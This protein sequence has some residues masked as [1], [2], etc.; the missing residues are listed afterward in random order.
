MASRI[1]TLVS[2]TLYIFLLVTFTIIGVA[3]LIVGVVGV[4]RYIPT[5]AAHRTHKN[6]TCLIVDVDYDS[7]QHSCYYVMWSVEYR[8]AKSNKYTFST[9]IKK[10]GTLG[11][12][13]A[14]MVNYNVRTNHT[15]YYNKKKIVHVQWEKPSSSK[16]YLIMMIVGFT[17]T[18][19]YIIIIT[20]VSVYRFRRTVT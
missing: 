2:C 13:L 19:I 11:E 9:I 17:L 5:K 1:L 15:C 12:A 18:G 10:Y 16:P 7:C 4:G 3:S 6:V 8:V 20:I 14:K